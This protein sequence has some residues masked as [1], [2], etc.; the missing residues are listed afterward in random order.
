[1]NEEDKLRIPDPEESRDDSPDPGGN[2]VL[3]GAIAFLLGLGIFVAQRHRATS[4]TSEGSRTSTQTQ[5]A[6]TETTATDGD[7]PYAGVVSELERLETNRLYDRDW[8]ERERIAAI[9]LGPRRLADAACRTLPEP[10]RDD[11]L[12]GDVHRELLGAVDRRVS[13][14]PWSCLLRRF[15]EDGIDEELGLHSEM[16]SF[17]EAFRVFQTSDPTA[18]RIVETYRRTDDRPDSEAFD[19]WLRLCGLNF[20]A[21]VGRACRRLLH[22]L[23]PDQGRDLLGVVE[24]HLRETDD[25]NP[26]YDLP[27]LFGGLTRLIQF[28][29][30]DTWRIASTDALPDY[31]ADLRLGAVLYL[32]RFVQSPRTDT[33]TRAA[34]ALSEAAGISI[35]AVHNKLRERWQMACKRAFRTNDDPRQP[36]APLLEIGSNRE[37]TTPTYALQYVLDSGAC[38]VESDK[39]R[40]YCASRRWH[41]SR[42]DELKSFF[43][44]TEYLKWKG[45]ENEFW[46][47]D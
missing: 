43:F 17:W 25:L 34:R 23:A 19:R 9:R 28:G 42:A 13:H 5:H 41:G 20:D 31:D 1:M 16:A 22:A 7:T 18:A 44:E 32:C 47:I 29:Q 38:E 6:A 40:W 45:E 4:P 12:S 11:S 33:V 8:T 27:Y 15:L 24:T 46:T 37:D 21:S 39:P 26:A 3:S 30:P 36:T 2:L 14:A 10:L 35:R